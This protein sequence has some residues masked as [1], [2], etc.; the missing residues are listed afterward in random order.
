MSVAEQSAIGLVR[1]I[2]RF[3]LP[4]D[5]AEPLDIPP[6]EW[7]FVRGTLAEQRLTGIAMAGVAAAWLRLS[8]GQTSELLDQHREAMLWDLELERL[9][10][11][12]TGALQSA[13]IEVVVLKGSALAHCFYPD[14][15]WRSFGDLDLLVRTRDWRRTCELLEQRSFHRDLP[16]PR[17][18]FDER[19][20]KAASHTHADGVS[21]DLHRTLVLGPFGLWIDPDELFD[22]I[23]WFPLGGRS[24]RR[25][26]DTT[27]LLHACLHASLGAW[28]P[29]LLP[30][31]DVAQ[32]VARGD[33]D[34]D[35]LAELGGAWRL[36]PVLSHALR[37]V[38]DTLR[39][40]LPKE[41]GAIMSLEPSARERKVLEAY[42]VRRGR[43][44][45]ALTVI[46]CIPGFRA[47]ASY[48]RALLVPDREFLAARGAR[49]ASP[50]SYLGRWL[51]PVRWLTGKRYRG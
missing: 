41:A 1:R 49:G 13:G 16:E 45:T 2:S 10:I 40:D 12:L 44:G 48:M 4:P 30:L 33:V 37:S 43:G 29:L 39:V 8:P 31:R 6:S 18:G 32:V 5:A 38:V 23:A 9:L 21:V 36:R 17:S 26:D 34:W 19:F 24:L 27:V 50:P 11:A 22:R 7:A 3:G 46:R 14:P 42:T 25:L 28:P 51:K 47:R 35:S 15:S 20:G